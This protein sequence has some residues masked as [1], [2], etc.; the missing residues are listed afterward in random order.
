MRQ[1]RDLASLVPGQHAEVVVPKKRFKIGI[2]SILRS[3][4]R[5]LRSENVLKGVFKQI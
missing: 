4:E 1:R 3:F 5:V 2:F